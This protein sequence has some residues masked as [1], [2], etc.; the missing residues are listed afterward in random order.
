MAKICF[1]CGKELNTGEKCN[2]RT[3]NAQTNN[4]TG[5]AS[6]NNKNKSYTSDEKEKK[7]RQKQFEK[8]RKEREKQR[9]KNE[10]SG[11]G[12][13]Y[14][15]NNYSGNSK[16]GASGSGWQA[17]RSSVLNFFYKFMTNQGF[18][19]KEPFHKKVGYSLMHTFLRPVSAIDAFICNKD[20]S[21]SLFYT[22]LFAISS[23]LLSV[24][25][26]RNGLISFVEGFVISIIFIGILT[27]LLLLSFRFFTKIKYS[28][29]NMLSTLS[30]SF[31]FMSLFIFIAASGRGNLLNSA[32]TITAAISAGTILHYLSLK[33]FSGLENDRL[34]TNI[35]LVYFVFYSIISFVLNLALPVQNFFTN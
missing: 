6:D 30:S 16:T 18:S 26:W 23:G 1:Y 7:I 25:F 27:G 29:M 13:S 10:K 2:C 21:I 17:H 28:F 12:K 33:R 35:I 22:F 31:V 5:K 19:K 32:G 20:K 15:Y 9:A 3:N 34:I 4:F 24:K 8:E 11:N 14:K